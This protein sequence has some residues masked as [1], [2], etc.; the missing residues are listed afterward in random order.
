MSIEICNNTSKNSVN[1]MIPLNHRIVLHNR[2]VSGSIGDIELNVWEWPGKPPTILFC[3]GASFNGRC[4]DDIIS[5]LP[6]QHIITFDLRGHGYSSKTPPYTFRV[7]GEDLAKFIEK[8]NIEQ[9]I[10]VG[11]SL[12][13][14]AITLASIL[15]PN[16]FSSIILLD[17]VFFPKSMLL[18][19]TTKEAELYLSKLL[20]RRNSW[21]SA[22]EM[23]DYYINN[24]ISRKWSTSMLQN[25]CT[26]GLIPKQQEDGSSA[27]FIQACSNE[28]EFIIFLSARNQESDIYEEL[29]EIKIPVHVVRSGYSYKHGKFDTS[30]TAPDLAT[31]FK[32]GR[33]SK[34]EGVSHFIPMEAPTVV[35]DLIKDILKKQNI[36]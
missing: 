14:Y 13:G 5:T 32:N 36:L 23:F 25:Y 3:H 18:P 29:S 19:T 1:E 20:Q 16:A 24:P 28:T 33:D 35:S 4:F 30:L 26:Y 11:H 10:G 12:G 2:P 9:A 8:L 22:K 7:Y 17:P 34:L 27:G 6:D 21:S 31:Y 15:N